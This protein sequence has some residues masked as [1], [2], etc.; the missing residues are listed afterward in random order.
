[1]CVI[2]E[3]RRERQED[4]EFKDL[5]YMTRSCLKNTKQKHKQKNP[6]EQNQGRDNEPEA[7]H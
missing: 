6:N 7:I 4:L 2:A 3:I 5:G 1:L